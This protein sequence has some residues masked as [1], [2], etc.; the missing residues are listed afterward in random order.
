MNLRGKTKI[1]KTKL[2]WSKP[3]IVK[4]S[5]KDTKLGSGGYDSADGAPWQ[6]SNGNWQ[7]PK[8]KS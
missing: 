7:E 1:N 4:L 5:V 6:D 8:G 2:K 3:D